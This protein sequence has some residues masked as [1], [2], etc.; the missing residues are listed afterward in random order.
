MIII[1]RKRNEKKVGNN[2]WGKNLRGETWRNCWTL[3]SCLQCLPFF[4]DLNSILPDD[5]SAD[6]YWSAQKTCFLQIMEI[7]IPNAVPKLKRNVPWMN[8]AIIADAITVPKIRFPTCLA[9]QNM[10]FLTFPTRIW[11]RIG[12]N[13]GKRMKHVKNVALSYRFPTCTKFKFSSSV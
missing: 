13:F 10:T 6:T 12:R 3:S 9:Y 8:C 1:P 7:C 2:I 4:I 11:Q 5:V